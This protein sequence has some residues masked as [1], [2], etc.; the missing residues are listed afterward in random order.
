MR[1][2]VTKARGCEPTSK[3]LAKAIGVKR[4]SVDKILC[5]GRE[6]RQKIARSYRRLVVS[7]AKGYQG[8]GL[9]F[10]DLIQVVIHL[11]LKRWFLQCADIQLYFVV[12]SGREHWP[13]PGGGEI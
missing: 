11:T 9:S 12:F 2:G 6:S 8:K 13:S 7:I 3:Q 5:D 10:Q 4:R 1:I